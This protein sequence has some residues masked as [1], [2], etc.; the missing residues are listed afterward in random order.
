MSGILLIGTDGG[1]RRFYFEQAA[2][3]AGLPVVF[4]DWK[5]VPDMDYGEGLEKPE[6]PGRKRF[7]E[8]LRMLL[9]IEDLQR[10]AV[11]IDAP[12][13]ESSCLC[14][15]GS[16]TGRYEEQLHRLSGRLNL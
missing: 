15:L 5:D 16:L 2:A 12:A 10:F 6:E 14:D 7:E 11:K 9:Q 13:W 4:L 1:K 8:K 3:E